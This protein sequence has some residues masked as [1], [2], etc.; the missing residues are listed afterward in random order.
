MGRFTKGKTALFIDMRWTKDDGFVETFGGPTIPIVGRDTITHLS[1]HQMTCVEEHKVSTGWGGPDE[2][3]DHDGYVF[4]DAEGY[5]WSINYD[6]SWLASISN[7]SYDENALERGF[8]HHAI[9]YLDKVGRGVRDLTKIADEMT[10]EQAM[11]N[12]R[13][14]LFTIKNGEEVKH[15][16]SHILV[17]DPSDLTTEELRIRSS[18]IAKH[19]EEWTKELRHVAEAAEAHRLE[20]IRMI[21]DQFGIEVTYKP[22]IWKKPDGSSF[23]AGFYVHAIE[24]EEAAA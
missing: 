8:R 20:V 3:K 13:N 18:E 22:Y 21:K 24:S 2:A 23:D 14:K 16:L 9:S 17:D 10:D 12:L 15:E 4:E 5:R 7:E 1:I 11:V 19:R 6:A